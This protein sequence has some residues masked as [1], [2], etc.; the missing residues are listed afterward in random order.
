[1]K[2]VEVSKAMVWALIWTSAATAR[3]SGACTSTAKAWVPA[4]PYPSLPL[5]CHLFAI[6]LQAQALSC[7]SKFEA[8]LK[9]EQ[10]ERKREEETRRLRQAAFREL[11]AAF[12]A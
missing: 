5:L 6:S 12:S 8:E 10:E 7:S 3:L 4:S 2:Q 9:A 11:K 1:M